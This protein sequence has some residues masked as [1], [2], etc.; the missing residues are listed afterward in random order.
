MRAQLY[1]LCFFIL[2][3]STPWA[4]AQESPLF[5]SNEML[6]VVLTAPLTQAYNESKKGERLWMAGKFAYK[7]NDGATKRVDIS[8]RT[9]GVFR[10]ANCKLPPLGLNFKKKEVKGT[11]FDGQDQLKLVA[12]CAK[13][14]QSQQDV[15]LE[16]L[17]YRSLEAMTDKSLRSRLLRVSYVDSDG[18]RKPWTH[19]GFVIEDDK[20][21]AKR[22][23][24]KTVKTPKLNRAEL[25]VETTAVVELFQ[26]MIGNTDYSTVTG[27][28]GKNCCHNVELVATTD[29]AG[30][31]IPVPYDF[32][33]A[34]LVNARYAKPPDHLPI[35]NVRKRYFTG[36]CRT[37]EIWAQTFSLFT[38]K[39]PEIMKLFSASQ[40]LDERNKKSSTEYMAAFFEMLADPV[41]QKKQIIGKCRE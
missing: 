26:L 8:I 14:E 37:D 2:G 39:R 38:Q 35:T 6:N 12:P 33:S 22:L 4:N 17:A 34:G 7:G 36:R 3:L 25:N 31:T 27:P 30:G 40:Y 5:Q 29:G 21:M 9:R 13:N 41:K 10:R 19:I 18:K 24:M 28:V 20:N 16:Y 15:I 1:T 32:D 11:L 23:G